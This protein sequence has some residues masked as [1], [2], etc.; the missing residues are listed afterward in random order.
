MLRPFLSPCLGTVRHGIPVA[1][2]TPRSVRKSCDKLWGRLVKAR[3]GDV[4]E[5]CGTPAD[6]ENPWA[7][8]AHHA[9]YRR[10]NYRLRF[11]PLNGVALCARCHDRAHAAPVDFV[12][13]LREHRG[14]DVIRCERL[15]VPEPV[16]R[17]LSDYLELEANLRR[18]LAEVPSEYEQ[19]AAA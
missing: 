1:K 19:G 3:A 2:R 8:H 17:S 16:H 9:I 15:N 6:P 11:E 12:D 7:F 13:W 14:E 18:M 10:T 4:C 5:R